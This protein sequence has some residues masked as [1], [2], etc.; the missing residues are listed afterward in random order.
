M[1]CVLPCIRRNHQ[2]WT[3]RYYTYSLHN[4]YTVNEH[5]P[6][7]NVTRLTLENQIAWK[8]ASKI[9]NVH[10][11]Y[12]VTDW[13][14]ARRISY[15]PCFLVFPPANSSNFSHC[16]CFSIRIHALLIAW[17]D[18]LYLIYPYQMLCSMHQNAPLK[19]T[20]GRT[21]GPSGCDYFPTGE[22]SWSV[23][24]QPWVHGSAQREGDERGTL[25]PH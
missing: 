15:F 17:I 8:T 21:P 18:T 4:I 3:Y 10:V 24:L 9:K 25:V 22:C 5:Y 1:N 14:S 19:K 2:H 20:W 7:T 13:S 12:V 23:Y 16:K 6:T 11:N